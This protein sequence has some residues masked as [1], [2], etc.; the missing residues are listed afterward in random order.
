[1][2]LR[3]GSLS[4]KHGWDHNSVQ[5]EC[6]SSVGC[7]LTLRYCTCT[8]EQRLTWDERGEG[9]VCQSGELRP[10]ASLVPGTSYCMRRTQKTDCALALGARLT[11]S[12][13]S[14]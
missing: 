10:S 8:I 1:M 13:K 14:S 7:T 4:S 11:G 6:P 5:R 9:G 3:S 2:A 12:A